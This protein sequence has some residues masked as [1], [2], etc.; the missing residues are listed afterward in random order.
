MSTTINNFTKQLHDNLEVFEDRAKSLRKN[1]RSVTKKN[2]TEIQSKLD[3]AKKNI[4][5]KKQQLDEYRAKLELQIQ[6]KD[7]EV[8]SNI[9]D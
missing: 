3:E 9:E 7:A 5:E 6:E 8:K 4:A 2:H 1:I